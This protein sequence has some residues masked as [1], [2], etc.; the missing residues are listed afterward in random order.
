MN[1][2]TVS[3]NGRIDNLDHMYAQGDGN[4]VEEKNITSL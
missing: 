3:R 1:Q 4:F 2:A